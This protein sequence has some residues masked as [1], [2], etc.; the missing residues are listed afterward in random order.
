MGNSG[1]RPIRARSR[2]CGA[3]IACAALFAA[4]TATGGQRNPIPSL[5]SSPFGSPTSSRSSPR[6]AIDAIPPPPEP[7]PAIDT[8][9]DSAADGLRPYASA[10][11]FELGGFANV[12]GTS[13][14]TSIQGSAA[15]G[16][17]VFDGF[18]LSGILGVNYVRQTIDAGTP[19]ARS[20]H[21]TIFRA[22]AEPSYH[23]PIAR[24]L[25]AFCGIGL[26]LSLALEKGGSDIGFDI[27][28]RAGGNF[29]VGRSGLVTLAAF[30][31]RTVAVATAGRGGDAT[32]VTSTYGLSAGYT[33][34]W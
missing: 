24:T 15:A 27:A 23:L 21:A 13:S 25:W 4:R 28:P 31:D 1:H 20:S 32:G 10:G 19:A 34:M 33:F 8:D 26:G 6:A 17:F 22:L 9:G 14:F 3:A 2:R 7:S 16:Y 5:A 11:V 18:E 12:S 30:F 29:L